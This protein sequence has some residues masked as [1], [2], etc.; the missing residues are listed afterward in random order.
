MECSFSLLT[1]P[2][3]EQSAPQVSRRLVSS[4]LSRLIHILT[5]DVAVPMYPFQLTHVFYFHITYLTGCTVDT[6]Q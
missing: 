6:G 2:D 3:E 4:R 5:I 1:P